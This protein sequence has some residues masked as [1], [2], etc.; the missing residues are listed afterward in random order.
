MS[1][2]V[3]IPVA[4]CHI[5]QEVLLLLTILWRSAI[6]R[7]LVAAVVIIPDRCE[8]GNGTGCRKAEEGYTDSKAWSILGRILLQ[9]SKGGDD[10]TDCSFC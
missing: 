5:T 7:R 9:E 6:G 3:G 1:S 2:S 8:V 4:G 10:S